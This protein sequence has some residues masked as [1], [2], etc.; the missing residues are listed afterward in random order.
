VSDAGR[1]LLAAQAELEAE[2]QA[3]AAAATHSAPPGAGEGTSA[4]PVLR[5]FV[6]APGG[7]GGAVIFT[8]LIVLAIVGPIVWASDAT[9][10]NVA[11]QYQP[12]SAAHPLGTDSLG[13]DTL[14]RTLAG[15]RLTL[16]LGL[17]AVSIAAA[18]GFGVGAV[19]SA[20]GPRLRAVVR[21]V[22]EISLSFPPIL[23]AL[24]FVAMIGTGARGA[25]IAIGLGAAPGFARLAENYATSVGSKEFVA[26]ARAAG[27]GRGRLVTRY[28]VPNMAEPLVLAGFAYFA[29]A[30]IDISGL[31]FLG[32]GVQPPSYDWGT[33]LTTGIGSIYVTP[34]AALGPALMIMITGMSI[35]YVG[36]AVARALNPR[37]WSVTTHHR[38]SLRRAKLAKAAPAQAAQPGSERERDV[39]L[40]VKD[41]RV[42]VP[43]REGQRG[44]IR[45]VSFQLRAGEVLAVVGETGSGKTLT[46]LSI[47]GLLPHPLRMQ[48]SLLELDGVDLGSLPRRR[49]NAVLGTTLAMIFQDPMSS[50]NPAARVGPQLTDG[51]RRHRSLSRSTARAEAIMRLAEVRI[52]DGRRAL[53]RYPHQFSGGMQQRIMIA[54]GLMARPRVLLADEP[55]TA[56]DVT[57]QAQV[58][59]VLREIKEKENT[60]IILISHN[61]GVV[62]QLCDRIL[63]MYAGRVVEEGTRERL[64]RRPRHPY[65]QGLLAS[66]PE[67]SSDE[68]RQ[69]RGIPGRPPAP[70]EEPAGC[71]FAPRCPLVIE[72]CRREQPE[73]TSLERDEK[74]ACFVAAASAEAEREPAAR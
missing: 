60:A 18:V 63:V 36:E 56:L 15:T 25:V 11:I 52:G 67:L 55:T 68:G 74:V 21:R 41:L 37:L 58:L 16:E 40:R 9:V 5:A 69:L 45:G 19:A 24:F 26:S 30:I 46:A 42:L 51:A 14:A 32:V 54:M 44:L 62:N 1:E 39:V 3:A 31:D 7:V 17:A 10:S 8:G 59:E 13:R 34:L 12:H 20:L 35:V 66:I 71:A 47:A 61:L 72:R 28:L 6:R 27:V 33:L 73:L 53:R 70:G 50:M 65:T 57:V 2:A 29:G 4:H 64:L 43:T 23:L 22:I 49:L 38:R 48:S